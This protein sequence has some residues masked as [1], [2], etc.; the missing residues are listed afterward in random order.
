MKVLVSDISPCEAG[1]DSSDLAVE[2]HVN[3]N[4]EHY[5]EVRPF[6]LPRVAGSDPNPS[7]VEQTKSHGPGIQGIDSDRPARGESS[8]EHVKFSL[9]GFPSTTPTS[10]AKRNQVQRECH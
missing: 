6:G 3:E 4:G 10:P 7:A 8:T 5:I 9:N 1:A 2:A